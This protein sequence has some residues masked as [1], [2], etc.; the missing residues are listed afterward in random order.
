ML[1]PTVIALIL[2]LVEGAT[3]FLPISSTGHLIVAGALLDFTG[4]RAATFEIVIQLGAILAVIWHYRTLL[5]DTVR[6]W[7][8]A[9][10]ERRLVL[11]LALAFVPAAVVGLLLH[12]WIK[13]AL[14]NPAVVAATLVVGGFA[15]LVVER[16]QPVSRTTDVHDLTYRQAFGVGLAQVL[17]LVPGTSRAAATILGGYLLGLT[18]PIATE[19]SFL[20]AIP[21]LVAATGYDM[22]QSRELFS[23]ADLPMFGIGLVVAFLSALLV[24]RALLRFVERHSFV[25]FAWYRI[26]FGAVIFLLLALGVMQGNAS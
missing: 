24:I 12:H 19:F 5:V 21:T 11:S 7:L 22:L 16:Q 3:E 1:P 17:S 15:I 18:R 26:A 6:R 14:F 10:A 2:G 23:A 13:A 8:R 25:V 4:E 20:L 9:P